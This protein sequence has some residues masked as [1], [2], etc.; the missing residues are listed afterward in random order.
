[1]SSGLIKRTGIVI[2]AVV[3]TTSFAFANDL[4]SDGGW[5][6]RSALPSDAV[7]EAASFGDDAPVLTTATLPP[8]R[9]KSFAQTSTPRVKPVYVQQSPVPIRIAQTAATRP[10]PLFWM[11]VGT[12]F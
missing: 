2:C 4:P 1:M 11:T 6:G 12:G 8:R 7:A 9:P 3:A 5:I 10:S